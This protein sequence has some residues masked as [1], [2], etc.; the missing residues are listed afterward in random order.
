MRTAEPLG[1]AGGI[2]AVVGKRV[3]SL[4]KRMGLTLQE[5]AKRA[6]ISVASL[7]EIETGRYAPRLDT[8]IRLAHALDVP[9]DALISKPDEALE[10][11]LRNIE[12]PAN[13]GA[14]QY[15]LERCRRYLQVEA[16]VGKQGVRAP[17]YTLPQGSWSE[18]LK[19]IEQIAQ[20]E[21]RRLNL[22]SEPLT[23]L[24][25]VIEWAGLRVIG[26]DLPPDDLDG[27]L[28]SF[29]QQDAA[30][31][32]INRAKP[33]LRQRFTLAHEY[34]HLL[35]HRD[36]DVIWDRSVFEAGIPEEREANAFAAA[37]LM[38]EELIERLYEEYRLPRQRGRLPMFG[39][40]AMR[41][42]LGVSTAALAWRLFNLGYIE[43]SERDW[44][45]DEGGRYLAEMERALY[46]E[47]PEPL[48]IPTLSD[49]L[50]TLILQAY[51]EE[52]LTTATAAEL[53]EQIL[54][55]IQEYLTAQRLPVHKAKH[56]FE[57]VEQFPAQGGEVSGK[58]VKA[59]GGQ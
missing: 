26:A 37:F 18:Q 51:R 35:L 6:E 47:I 45:L 53:L 16:L 59:M 19:R 32:L 13:T 36:R 40:L 46:G 20:E 38:P 33:P 8:I 4:R 43:E 21:R 54:T 17:N 58:E 10:A 14:L 56:F 22:G 31:A 30:I 24:M 50:R 7:S 2:A 1:N 3:R 9:L 49:R 34:G 15:W 42:R 39:W 5:L 44:M 28:L 25:A 41:R 55:P 57:F 52:E 27:A 48:P 29:P 12:T 23:D 11:R